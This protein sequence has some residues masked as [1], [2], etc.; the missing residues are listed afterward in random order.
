MFPF[1]SARR[2]LAAAALSLLAVGVAHAQ[3]KYPSRP[4]KMLIPYT[5]GAHADL[6]ARTVAQ[7]LSEMWGQ[8]VSVEN[9]PGGGGSIGTLAGAQSTPD[10]YTLVMSSSGVLLVN[11]TLQSKPPYDALRDFE[12]VVPL[13]STAWMLYVHPD[14]GVT[15]LKGLVALA[16]ANPGKLNGATPGIGTTNHLAIE[17]LALS[18]GITVTPVHY[19]GSA[20]AM[21]D[22]LAGQTQFM[23]DSL[24]QMQHVQAGKLRALAVTSAQRSK[25][26]PDVPTAAEA[27]FPS[28]NLTTWFGF[29]F[30]AKTP[31]D[32][33]ARVNADVTKA[34]ESKE[35]QE[36]LAVAGFTQMNANVEGFRK[37]VR[38]DYDMYRR[39]I[40][41]AK[42]QLN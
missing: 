42:I 20:G 27:G 24:L 13:V 34:M 37:I 35:V 15:D 11:P 8:P 1:T 10:G 7:K 32:I 38:D 12:P 17:L 16:K 14:T 29:F 41:E 4:V 40:K 23:F 30:P 3:D 26:A 25:I 33:V 39:V 5:P 21:T 9:R 6:L 28:L 2:I 36:R 22:L 31:A 18:S 19:K